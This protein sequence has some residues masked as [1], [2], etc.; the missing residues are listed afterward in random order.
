MHFRGSLYH[1]CDECEKVFKTEKTLM[2]HKR[3][4]HT[5]KQEYTCEKCDKT[6]T[7][8]PSLARHRREKHSE[9]KVNW[10]QVKLG[11]N[12]NPQSNICGNYIKRESNL[13][14]HRKTVHGS[15]DDSFDISQSCQK[16][17]KVFS[18]KS[19]CTR[20]IRQCQVEH[21][22]VEDKKGKG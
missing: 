8:K 22:E 7:L 4:A 5:S 17:G 16:C 15:K 9:L 12:L 11:E 19:N 13:K 10:D 3:Y 18:S 21:K 2:Q 6:F 14:I 1:H 20:H